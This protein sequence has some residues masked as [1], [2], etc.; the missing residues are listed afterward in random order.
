MAKVC[1]LARPVAPTAT[2]RAGRCS[3][4]RG[5]EACPKLS[6][7]S[8]CLFLGRS[9]STSL[10]HP[11]F[12]RIGGFH[13]QRPPVTGIILLSPGNALP[14]LG[15]DRMR[16]MSFHVL[17][18][19]GLEGLLPSPRGPHRR[20]RAMATSGVTS[21]ISPLTGDS[22]PPAFTSPE[23]HAG[24][25][26]YFPETDRPASSGSRR[27]RLVAGTRWSLGFNPSS[28]L[29]ASGDHSQSLATPRDERANP[30][31]P[32]A[33]VA[34]PSARCQRPPAVGPCL[35]YPRRHGQR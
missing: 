33:A 8:S 2:G 10:R 12:P 35:P 30:A 20:P 23:P 5:I 34:A 3:K 16:F 31:R 27:R 7:A 6:R 22:R 18:E 19:G 32:T 15:L 4:R 21:T 29:V 28:G 9:R 25:K 13:E 14:R 11:R 17:S 26:P 1:E 24:A